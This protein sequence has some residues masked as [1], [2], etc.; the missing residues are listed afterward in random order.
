MLFQPQSTYSGIRGLCIL[1]VFSYMFRT[2]VRLLERGVLTVILHLVD[3]ER[4]V[5]GYTYNFCD[6]QIEL[7][8]QDFNF[9]QLR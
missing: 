1:E 2:K 5:R 4:T 3:G 7:S 8:E 9:K 6:R